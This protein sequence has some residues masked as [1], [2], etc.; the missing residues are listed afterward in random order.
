MM[1]TRAPESSGPAAV[2]ELMVPIATAAM[3]I[4]T[5]QNASR[6]FSDI[7]P[8]TA[9]DAST[10]TAEASGKIAEAWLA[11]ACVSPSDCSEIGV[12]LA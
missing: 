5:A 1:A 9:V 2:T 4:V 12:R 8:Q 10:D 11:A 3:V 6:P 7:F